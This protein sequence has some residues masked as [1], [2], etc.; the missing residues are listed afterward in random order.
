[1]T[2]RGGGPTPTELWNMRGAPTGSIWPCLK[3]IL[4]HRNLKYKKVPTNL[5]KIVLHAYRHYL[6]AVH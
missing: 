3:Q 2:A 1:M 6:T 4:L 5:E